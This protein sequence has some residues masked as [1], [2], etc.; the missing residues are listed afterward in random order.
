MIILLLWRDEEIELLLVLRRILFLPPGFWVEAEDEMMEERE[1]MGPRAAD[2][3]NWSLVPGFW[4]CW[5]AA[6]D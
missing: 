4:D 2:L 6:V 3:G 5:A 1:M